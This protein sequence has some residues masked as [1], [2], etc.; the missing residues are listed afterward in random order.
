MQGLINKISTT[1][2]SKL[3]L[4]RATT[5][6][7]NEDFKKYH[8]IRAWFITKQSFSMMTLLGCRIFRVKGS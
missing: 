7:S 2:H 5:Y 4:E 3:Q 6:H 8:P 1:R